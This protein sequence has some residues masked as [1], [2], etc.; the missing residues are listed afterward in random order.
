[1]KIRFSI[2]S[3]YH[4]LSCFASLW[5]E[6]LAGHLAEK[7]HLVGGSNRQPAQECPS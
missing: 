1:M 3:D 6:G 2:I 4:H 7:V 5:T